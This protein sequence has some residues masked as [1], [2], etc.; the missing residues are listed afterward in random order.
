[1]SSD[2]KRLLYIPYVFVIDT[3]K[4]ITVFNLTVEMIHSKQKSSA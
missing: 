3:R 1:M 2:G 4:E